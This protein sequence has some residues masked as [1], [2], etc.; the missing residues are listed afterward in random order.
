MMIICVRTCLLTR[1]TILQGTML[2]RI[3]YNMEMVIERTKEG[4]KELTIVRFVHFLNVHPLIVFHRVFCLHH[5]LIPMFNDTFDD[6]ESGINLD[7]VWNSGTILRILRQNR[8]D[9]VLQGHKHDPEIFVLDS[10]IFL[11]GGSLLKNLPRDIENS[12]YSIQVD[13]L[14]TI[15]KHSL[16]SETEAVV[17]CGPNKR[18]LPF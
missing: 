11:I 2:D 14:I 18:Y 9:L 10:T 7:I 3:D 12:F 13:E 15:R 16:Q 8:F 1:N 6:D 17:H 4:N 5:H